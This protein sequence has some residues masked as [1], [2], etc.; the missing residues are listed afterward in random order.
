MKV[1]P[2]LLYLSNPV[3]WNPMTSVSASSTNWG[4]FGG[5]IVKKKTKKHIAPKVLQ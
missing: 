4:K 3:L 1:E 5:T 2:V